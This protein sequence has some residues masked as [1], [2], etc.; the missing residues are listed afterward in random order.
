MGWAVLHAARTG[1]GPNKTQGD[2]WGFPS[3]TLSQLLKL[4]E[5]RSPHLDGNDSYRTHLKKS[6]GKTLQFLVP[7]MPS[8]LERGAFYIHLR[9]TFSPSLN[10]FA[11]CGSHVP[12]VVSYSTV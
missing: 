5:P 4:P 11:F 1:D 10:S 9:A 6:L 3:P 8:N 12:R 2:S 7:P